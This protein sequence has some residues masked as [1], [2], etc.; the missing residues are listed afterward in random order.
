MK[1]NSE[2]T[3]TNK[4]IVV[5][6]EKKVRVIH[7]KEKWNNKKTVIDKITFIIYKR[8]KNIIIPNFFKY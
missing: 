6:Y 3:I 1:K 2:K 4:V 5:I 8:N 7:L